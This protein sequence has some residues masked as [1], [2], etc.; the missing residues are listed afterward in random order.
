[1]NKNKRMYFKKTALMF[2]TWRVPYP[3]RIDQ[4]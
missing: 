3:F 2:C 1:M 4:Y